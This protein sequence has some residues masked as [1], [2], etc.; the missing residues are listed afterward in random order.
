MAREDRIHL[1]GI[2]YDILSASMEWQGDNAIAELNE[3]FA[4]EIKTLSDKELVDFIT[5]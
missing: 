1:E 3:A 5:A 4:R 2:A